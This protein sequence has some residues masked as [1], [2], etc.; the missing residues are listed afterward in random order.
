M[1]ILFS[2]DFMS[3]EID[4]GY[5]RLLMDYGSGTVSVEQRQI[6]LTDGK[7]HKVDILWSRTVSCFSA[8]THYYVQPVYFMLNCLF[9]SLCS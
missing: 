5:A 1:L 4:R 6:K 3:L 9:Q 7:S 2:T 8:R